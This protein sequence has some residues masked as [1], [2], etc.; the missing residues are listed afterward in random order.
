LL[1]RSYRRIQAY[2]DFYRISSEDF[3]FFEKESPSLFKAI[4]SIEDTPL[5][6]LE[7]MEIICKKW[8]ENYHSLFKRRAYFRK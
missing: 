3:L 4:D 8:V 2:Y 6:K 7:E 1:N 5:L